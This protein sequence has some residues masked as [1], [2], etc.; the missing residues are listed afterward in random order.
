MG[1]KSGF[2]FW[3]INLLNLESRVV[4]R[5]FLI[6]FDG[7]VPVEKPLFVPYKILGF[8]KITE[9]PKKP[10]NQQ[11]LLGLAPIR[12]HPTLV[13]RHELQACRLAHEQHVFLRPQRADRQRRQEKIRSRDVL[14]RRCRAILH[15]HFLFPLGCI[16]S[17]T[18]GTV[19]WASK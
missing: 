18:G 3:P 10:K 19:C 6:F 5:L 2:D 9:N 14:C 13:R 17:Q 1:T 4:F 12:R 15:R 11:L 7:G 16:R 8:R